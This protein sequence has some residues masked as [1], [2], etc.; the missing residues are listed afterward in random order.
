MD[1]FTIDLLNR[2]ECI[3][4]PTG[5]RFICDPPVMNTDEDT[6]VYV[7]EDQYPALRNDLIAHGYRVPAFSF[8]N[9]NNLKGDFI[10]YKKGDVN[11]IV[12]WKSDYYD[13][14]VHATLCAKRLNL[15]NKQDRIKLFE[16]MIYER[17]GDMKIPQDVEDIVPALAG[18]EE[19]EKQPEGTYIN[20]NITT[21]NL[22]TNPFFDVDLNAQRAHWVVNVIGDQIDRLNRN[23]VQA[24]NI[25]PRNRPI[26]WLFEARNNWRIRT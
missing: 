17:Y 12:T 26:D 3:T 23:N 24:N 15:L 5:S 14:Y 20:T 11:L 16:G 22:D 9:Y 2:Y 1:D 19:Q 4:F 8:A 21:T 18:G 25:A 10:S 7:T 13:K 6:V